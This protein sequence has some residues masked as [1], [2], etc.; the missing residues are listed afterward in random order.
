MKLQLAVAHLL[1]VAPSPAHGGTS[2]TR[3]SALPSACIELQDKGN[4]A[5]LIRSLTNAIP[6][7]DKEKCATTCSA[8]RDCAGIS[9]FLFMVLICRLRGVQ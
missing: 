2:A 8:D 1:V 7:A 5:V 9:V 4:N 6:I 3:A